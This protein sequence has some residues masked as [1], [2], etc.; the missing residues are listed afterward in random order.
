MP[1]LHCST[2]SQ[3]PKEET[4]PEKKHLFPEV[5]S[6]DSNITPQKCPKTKHFC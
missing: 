2:V 3:N 1:H 5:F 6:L 4:L